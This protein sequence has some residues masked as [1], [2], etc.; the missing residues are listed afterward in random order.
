MD[1]VRALED[2]VGAVDS[3]DFGCHVAALAHV[4]HD[5]DLAVGDVTPAITTEDGTRIE[6]VHVRLAPSCQQF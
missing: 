1:P 3:Y 4:T 5:R 2:E 6:R